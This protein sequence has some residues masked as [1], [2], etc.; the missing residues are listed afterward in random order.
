MRPTLEA[1]WTSASTMAAQSKYSDV[2]ANWQGARA[3]SGAEHHLLH[4]RP[5]AKL[6]SV[7]HAGRGGKVQGSICRAGRSGG[8]QLHLQTSTR[9]PPTRLHARTAQRG[10]EQQQ[11]VP[12]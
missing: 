11:P 8:A 3:V 1:V 9:W 4:S 7:C 2:G 10:D 6:G 12:K 5:G